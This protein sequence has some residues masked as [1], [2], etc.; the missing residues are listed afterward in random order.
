MKKIVMTAEQISEAKNKYENGQSLLLISSSYGIS[1]KILSR[2]FRENNINIRT[3]KQAH[4]TGSKIKK[5]IQEK[6]FELNKQHIPLQ[7]IC[8]EMNV[9]YGQLH[10][11]LSS[12]K[13][14]W[15]RR[16][17]EL[18]VESI[19]ENY[20]SGSTIREIAQKFESNWKTIRKILVDNE[21]QLK[22]FSDY[23]TEIPEIHIL[24]EDMIE[25]YKSLSTVAAEISVSKYI[26]KNRFIASGLQLRTKSQEQ[27]V[28]NLEKYPDFNFDFFSHMTPEA[29]YWMGFIAADGAVIG[30][31]GKK[32]KLSINLKISDFN[33]LKKLSNLLRHGTV[34]EIDMSKYTGTIGKQFVR[35]TKMA[36]LEISSTSLCRPLVENGIT[37]KKTHSLELSSKL[38]KSV[39]FW[40]G[41][42]DGDGSITPLLNK[43]GYVSTVLSL[44]GGSKPV[45]EAFTYFL[46]GFD[47]LAPD[48]KVRHDAKHKNPFYVIYISGIRARKLIKILYEQAPASARLE[49][50]FE[51]ALTWIEYVDNGLPSNN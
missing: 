23:R 29:L 1:R 3:P 31:V 50:K 41:Y 39:D 19:I 20:K 27:E 28:V 33:H 49:R 22:D 7:Q 47:I 8:N 51:R 21:V 35:G 36:K 14:L 38:L 10:R 45:L 4:K 32:L 44:G 40:R 48:I 16:F 43:K 46:K 13:L 6:I 30:T 37:P 12:K 11:L 24:Y 34:K 25:N 42:I 17:K 26:L 5:E 18:P 9:S 2:V 15:G